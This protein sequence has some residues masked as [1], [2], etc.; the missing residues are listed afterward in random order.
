MSLKHL[1]ILFLGFIFFSCNSNQGSFELASD[2]FSIVIDSKGNLIEYS[3]AASGE[4]H[5]VTDTLSPLMSI[6][7]D[8]VIHAPELATFD[9]EK[10]EVMLSYPGDIEVVIGVLTTPT[11]VSFE[12]LS[13]NNNQTIEMIIWGPYHTRLNEAIGETVGV[14]QGE[15]FSLGLQA[16]NPK[17]LGGYPWN[18]NDCMPQINIFNQDDL[19]DMKETPDKDYVLYRVEAAKPTDKGSSLQAY[20]RNRFED[21]LIQ[22]LN[23]D[24]Y[25]APTYD[26]GGV[27]GSKIAL[28]GTPREKTLE[29]I[30]Q[31]E[32]V[33]GLPHPE[34][35]GTW[36]KMAPEAT[37]AYIIM[38][39]SKNDIDKAIEITKKAGLNY[40]YHDGPFDTWGHFQLQPDRFPNGVED[41]KYCVEKAEAAGLKMGVH[42]LSNFIT[43]NDGYVTPVPDPRLAKVGSSVLTKNINATQKEIPIVSPDFFNQFKN[44]HLKTVQINDELI[45]YGSVSEQEPWMLL[46]CERGS[47][48]T[49][50]S[51]HQANDIIS[52]LIDHGYKVFLSNADLSKEMARNIADFFNET[53][54]RQISFDGL[55]GN[56]STGM[57]NYGEILFTQTWFD[58]LNDD[59]KSHYIADA[60]RTSHYFWHMYTRMN[61]GEPWYAG[62]RESQTEYRLKNQAYFKRNLMPGMLGW[63]RMTAETS[64]EDIEWMLARS[65]AFDAGYAFVVDYASLEKNQHTDQILQLIG[66]WESV[67]ISGLFSAEQK[68]LMENANNEYHLEKFLENSWYLFHINSVKYQHK[69]VVKQPGEPTYATV[70]FEL[71]QDKTPF[72]FNLTARGG[73]ISNISFEMDNYRK[74]EIPITLQ[75]GQTIKYAGGIMA[76]IFDKNWKKIGYVPVAFHGYTMAQGQHSVNFDCEFSDEA[77]EAALELRLLQK[78]DLIER[79]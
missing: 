10:A 4:N 31:I 46:D 72:H 70:N 15:D 62:F 74:V 75:T 73:D 39:F 49:T 68:Q 19:S 48:G 26:D 65:A 57:G 20:C 52:K 12:L 24:R 21:R 58:N 69:K 35:D 8:S 66:E 25:I 29:T 38:N 55:E 51:V 2:H 6:R 14:V 78:T 50:V 63:F 61:W 5:L 17:T 64:I 59:I 28:F 23:H 7:V 44:N 27:I 77:T 60:S 34:L 54:L 9:A 13:I 32:V 45:R 56:R 36:T 1:I 22:N 11:H 33:E 30:G 67:R 3:D 18:D 41:L 16:L 43:T 37:S 42:T 79:K 47:F 40:L 76:D 71:A 53:G